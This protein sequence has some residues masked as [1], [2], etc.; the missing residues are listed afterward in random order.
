MES[1][2]ETLAEGHKEVLGNFATPD[3]AHCIFDLVFGFGGE[4]TDTEK[5]VGTDRF[6][7]CDTE[8]DGFRGP[9]FSDQ[10]ELAL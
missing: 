3:M 1:L 7:S 8:G 2:G 4:A 6:H 10:E 9:D 5:V